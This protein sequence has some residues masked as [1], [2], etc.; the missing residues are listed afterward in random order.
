MIRR[1]TI[2]LS[3]VLIAIALSLNWIVN[4]PV[5]S[6]V[7]ANNADTLPQETP[8]EATI[9]SIVEPSDAEKRLASASQTAD[10][11][12]LSPGQIESHP[13]FNA[14]YRRLDAVAI[15]GPTIGSYRGLSSTELRNLATQRDSAAMAVLGAIS[16]LRTR[17]IAEDKAVPYLLGE[18]AALY[19]YTSNGQLEPEAIEHLEEAYR[20]FYEAALHGRLLALPFAGEAIGAL[21]GGAVGMGWIEKDEYDALRGFSKSA[22]M[23]MTVYNALAFEIAPQLREGPSGMIYEMIPSN[24]RQ[25]TIVAALA[26]EFEKDREEANLPPIEIAESTA[27]PLEDIRSMLC[28]SYLELEFIAE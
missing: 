9:A 2:L 5:P 28:E 27:P 19:T 7:D 16:L 8:D 21:E 26:E 15:S 14:D 23:P 17:N 10:E 6:G 3:A 4:R 25:K 22:F 11:S 18:D 12:C 13:M 20:W 24:D 1:K